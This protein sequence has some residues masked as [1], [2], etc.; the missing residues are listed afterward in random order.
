LKKHDGSRRHRSHRL[1]STRTSPT[2]LC[3]SNVAASRIH[4]KLLPSML[5]RLVMLERQV[6]HLRSGPQAPRYEASDGAESVFLHASKASRAG[7]ARA[8]RHQ[9]KLPGLVMTR[10]ARCSFPSLQVKLPV[11]P[12]ARHFTF[13][14]RTHSIIHPFIHPPLPASPL[15]PSSL[16]DHPPT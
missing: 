7:A 5:Q 16:P 2:Q 12:R 8:S 6:M 10:L 14:H 1:R 3:N 4:P 13:Q 11:P 15:C 9:D